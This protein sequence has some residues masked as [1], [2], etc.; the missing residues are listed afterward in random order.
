MNGSTGVGTRIDGKYLIIEELGRGGMSTVWLARDERLG[1]LWA[2]KEIR[3]G[4]GGVHEAAFRQSMI[5]EANLM[6]RLD[7]VAIP[8]VVD[9]LDTGASVFVVMDYVEGKALSKALR[10][11]GRPFSQEQVID[12]GI[13]LCDVLGYLHSLEPPVVYR[14]MKP[15]NVMLR[16]DGQVKLIDF[17]IAMACDP[18]ASGGSGV[19]GTP[20]YAAPE[21][22]A[23]DAGKID[24][25]ADVYALGVTLYSLV[26]GQVPRRAKEKA[27][28]DAPAFALRPIR[29]WDPGL[30][31]GLER[32]ILKATNADP[33]LR[34]GCMEDMRYD[35]QHHERLTTQWR[36]AQRR[37]VRRFLGWAAGSVACMV[38]GVVL[39]LWAGSVRRNSYLDCL[40][41]AKEASWE[42][43]GAGVSEAESL[44]MQAIA[45][46]HRSTDAY[47]GLLDVYERDF[48]LTDA[49]ESR[50]HSAFERVGEAFGNSRFAELCFEV[51]TCYLSYF[52]T[53]RSGGSV[54]NAA[55]ESIEA[56][57]PWFQRAVESCEGERGHT[58]Q[59]IDAMDL[60]AAQS[61]LVIAE[62][63]QKVARAG[64]EGRSSANEYES[65]W[66]SIRA[67]I[68]K[69]CEAS[70][71]EKG[72]E[73]VRIRL[74]QV[75][76]ESIASTT[77]LLGFSHAGVTEEQAAELLEWVRVC[78]E[79][80]EEFVQLEE[81]NVVY[82]P[83][84]DEIHEGLKTADHTIRIVYGNPVAQL[85]DEDGAEGEA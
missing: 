28:L 36:E 63:H 4:M 55:L 59:A 37:K 12:W 43:G 32:V 70:G 17:G 66:D 57:A 80:M 24:P 15:S 56:A 11:R 75:A 27:R 82:G 16:E 45:L 72:T 46:D 29:E 33:D 48:L 23:D 73:G 38:L 26:T 71:T 35:L 14:D 6:K 50:L 10:K 84:L 41:R 58:E 42:E 54:G 49:E 65:F 67:C 51:G 18:K 81:C 22:M 83:V 74:C 13:Q 69:E 9:I 7:H 47:F 8:R 52:K 68:R 25:R 3:Q 31:E 2:I 60:E 19:V 78:V 53:D 44:Y 76:V 21:Q 1:K 5:D 79:D 77:Y 20:G 34:Y 85:K 64:R 30:S 39:L 61:Y 62:F 40:Y